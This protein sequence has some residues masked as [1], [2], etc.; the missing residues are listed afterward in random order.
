MT[1]DPLGQLYVELIR[2]MLR[3]AQED[4]RAVCA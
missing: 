4:G 3:R 2:E 1:M